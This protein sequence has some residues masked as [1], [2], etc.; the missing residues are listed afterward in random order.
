MLT[1]CKLMKNMRPSKIMK[2]VQGFHSFGVLAR[3]IDILASLYD[4]VLRV[5]LVDSSNPVLGLV[6]MRNHQR[7]KCLFG[8]RSDRGRPSHAIV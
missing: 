4:F 2:G 6:T 1:L 7:F 5:M 3:R 8:G